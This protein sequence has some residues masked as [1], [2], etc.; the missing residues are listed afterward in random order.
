MAST[1]E[2][3]RR[4]QCTPLKGAENGLSVTEVQALLALL[5]GWA[6]SD[7]GKTISKDYPFKNFYRTMGF[8]NAIAWMANQQDHHPD[9]DLGYGHCLVRYSTHDVGGLSINDFICAARV[10]ALA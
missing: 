5:P 6:Q 9:L 2:E 8:A 10:E 1:L 4:S 3:L 7:D